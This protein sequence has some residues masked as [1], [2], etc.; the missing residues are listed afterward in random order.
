MTIIEKTVT[1]IILDSFPIVKIQLKF[2]ANN[3][4]ELL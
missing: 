4:V 2:L 3:F 1:I